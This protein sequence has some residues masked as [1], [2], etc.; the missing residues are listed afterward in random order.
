MPAPDFM[1]GSL[2]STTGGVSTKIVCKVQVHDVS[3][4]AF[5]VSRLGMRNIGNLWQLDALEE[6]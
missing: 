6:V 2:F 5:T 3:M 1:M 4:T